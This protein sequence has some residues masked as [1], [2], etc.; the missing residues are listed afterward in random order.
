M[1]NLLLALAVAG[2]TYTNAQAQGSENSKFAKNYPVCLKGDKY[3]V[4]NPQEAMSPQAGRTTE[5]N[6][7]YGMQNT[8]VHMGYGTSGNARFRGRIR[9]TYDQP[10]A[11]YEGKETMTND[12]VRK[13][14]QRNLNTNN[15]GYDLPPNDGGSL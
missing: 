5:T 14:K 13:N 8:Y 3:Q 7:V 11:V 10:G 15:G 2:L 9:V 4:C 6:M 12:G 1:K